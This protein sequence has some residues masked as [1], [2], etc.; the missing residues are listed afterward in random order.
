MSFFLA[1]LET[2]RESEVIEVAG[3][4]IQAKRVA[5]RAQ[6]QISK[7]SKQSFLELIQALDNV[8]RETLE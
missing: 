8:S 6:A 5:V 1:L 3:K 7:E 2:S 4:A